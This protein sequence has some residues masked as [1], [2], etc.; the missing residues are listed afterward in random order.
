MTSRPKTSLELVLLLMMLCTSLTN[1][2][3][4]HAMRSEMNSHWHVLA[5]KRKAAGVKW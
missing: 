4:I 1:A 2:V 5:E 3:N